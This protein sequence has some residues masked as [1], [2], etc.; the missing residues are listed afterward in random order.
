MLKYTTNLVIEVDQPDSVYITYPNMGIS[1]GRSRTLFAAVQIM[2]KRTAL[3]LPELM[4][5]HETIPAPILK[6]LSVYMN[7]QGVLH[8]YY[9]DQKLL[10]N[11]ERILRRI[12]RKTFAVVFREDII[13][14]LPEHVP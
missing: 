4:Y 11:L 14:D 5:H 12:H 2:D 1:D 8:I 13:P 10:M 6:D 3:Y 7:A 9:V